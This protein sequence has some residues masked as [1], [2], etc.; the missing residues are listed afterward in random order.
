MI[1]K[2][3]KQTR[4]KISAHKLY[5]IIDEYKRE[6]NITI[7]FWQFLE[8][9][10]TETGLSKTSYRRIDGFIIYYFKITDKH[11][12]LLAKIKYGF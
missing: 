1:F 10:F 9:F 3:T 5:D 4:I 11:K 6:R 8:M 2:I 12:Y 7:W